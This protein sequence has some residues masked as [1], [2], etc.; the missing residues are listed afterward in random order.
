VDIAC[1]KGLNH[2][3]GP[4]RLNDLTGLDLAFDILQ[5]R[6]DETGEK[7]ICYDLIKS[8]YDKG[9]YGKKAGRGFYEYDKK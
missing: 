9:W 6:Y 5:R 4:F 8:Y 2:P 7:P 3:M 1:E